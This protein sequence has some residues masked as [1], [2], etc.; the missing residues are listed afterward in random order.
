[1][2][3]ANNLKKQNKEKMARKEIPGFN[4]PAPDSDRPRSRKEKIPG[5]NT[6]ADDSDRPR[7]RKGSSFLKNMLDA[8]GVGVPAD[9]SD[10]PRS[11]KGSSFL[12]NISNIPSIGVPNQKLL[13]EEANKKQQ[14]AQKRAQIE[15]LQQDKKD[16]TNQAKLGAVTTVVGLAIEDPLMATEGFIN[17][18]AG[19]TKRKTAKERIKSVKKNPR[20]ANSVGSRTEDGGQF[21]GVI[22]KA[23][24]AI[25]SKIFSKKSK[26][27]ETEQATQTPPNASSKSERAYTPPNYSDDEDIIEG[28]FTVV[29]DGKPKQLTNGKKS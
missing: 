29:D 8:P 1:M 23:A 28:E 3:I 6:P 10:R 4:A 2:L 18:A 21:S 12:K 13:E 11:R 22:K 15:A 27:A 7:S 19:V 24:S 16:A 14:G 20:A 9:D 26:P 17:T 25:F 5:F